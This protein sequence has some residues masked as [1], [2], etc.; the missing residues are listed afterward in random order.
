M[1][2]YDTKSVSRRRWLRGLGGVALGLP[3]LDA[4]APRDAAARAAGV[5]RRFGVFF[6]CNGVD[7]GRW[8]PKGPYGV[9]N[10]AHFAGTANEALLPFREKLLFPRGLHMAPRGG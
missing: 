3:F 9:L 8:F 1:K 4:L 10:E 5:V 7:V 2:L 6:C